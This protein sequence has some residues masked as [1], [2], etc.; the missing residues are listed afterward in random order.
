MAVCGEKCCVPPPPSRRPDPTSGTALIGHTGFVGGHLL[1][2]RSFDARFN[3][4]DIETI[5]GRAFSEIVCAGVSAVKWKANQEPEADWRGIQRLMDCLT[6]VSAGH[7]TLISTIDVYRDPIGLT[8]RDAP[9]REGLHPYGLH[10]LALEAF[11][12]ER[13]PSHTIVRLPALF[14]EGLRK[15][16]IF[17]LMTGN[18]TDRIIPNAAFQWYPLRRIGADLATIVGAGTSLINIT[19]EPVTMD[20]IRTLFFPGVALAEPSP[21]PPRYDLR[22]IHDA[23]LGGHDGYHLDATTVLEELAAFLTNR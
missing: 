15:N 4:R 21:S 18:M 14:G 3:S 11:I 13:F 9:T 5:R 16:A 10:R 19:A 1:R 2:Q 17:D 20:A 23:L 7:F 6:P 8:E 22:S 12:A